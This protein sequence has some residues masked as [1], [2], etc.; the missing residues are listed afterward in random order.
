MA[1]RVVSKRYLL[2]GLIMRGVVTVLLIG[3]IGVGLF[4]PA[5]RWLTRSEFFKVREIVLAPS[6]KYIDPRHLYFLKGRSMFDIQLDAIHRRLRE[7]YPEVDALRIV[8]KFPNRIYISADKREPVA[9]ILWGRNQFIVD[10]EG[11]VVAPG[12]PVGMRLPL[13]RGLPRGKRIVFGQALGLAE[14]DVA[15]EIV[16]AFEGNSDVRPFFIQTI[17]VANLAQIDC[18]MSNGLVFRIDPEQIETKIAK[19]GIVLTDGKNSLQDVTYIDLRFQEP[20]L[21]KGDVRKGSS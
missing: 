15:L 3:G 12:P 1:R 17:D 16:G 21:G 7:R 20:I 14:L 9:A 11:V 19:L 10:R 5:R 4:V 8:R 18:A 2:S 6:L 13:V